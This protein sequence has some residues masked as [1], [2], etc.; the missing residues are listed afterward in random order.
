[1]N[2]HLLF[3]RYFHGDVVLMLNLVVQRMDHVHDDPLGAFVDHEDV[4]NAVVPF[5]P[6]L[7]SCKGDVKIKGMK[8]G[9]PFGHN[10][11]DPVR[12]VLAETTKVGQG[13]VGVLL[14]YNLQSG[15]KF[16]F[17]VVVVDFA[18]KLAGRT[19]KG[20]HECIGRLVVDAHIVRR[21]QDIWIQHCQI[22]GMPKIPC[23]V[24]AIH[25][26]ILAGTPTR[27]RTTNSKGLK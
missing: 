3:P 21:G 17:L 8:F 26:F 24:H 25:G 22:V 15:R 5:V 19:D 18:L 12:F 2:G 16:I 14:R 9:D 20:L 27:R 23:R 7:Q 4:G 1:M 13:H 6:T 11:P 10:L